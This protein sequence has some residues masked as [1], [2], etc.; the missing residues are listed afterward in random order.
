MKSYLTLTLASVMTASAAP[1]P[2]PP[3]KPVDL[4]GYRLSW[5]DEFDEL[6]IGNWR[7]DGKRWIAHTPW[8]GDFGDARF[9]GPGADSAF[10]IRD[11]IL[12]ITARKA[13]NGKWS[14]GLIS[15]VDETGAGHGLSEGYFET[16]IKVTPGPGTW[17][18]FWLFSKTARSDR[19][20]K[21]EIDALEFYGH[22]PRSFH[23][24]WKVHGRGDKARN[25]GDLKRIAIEPGAMSERFNTIGIQLTRTTIRYLFNRV[26]VWSAPRP[27]ELDTPM[28]PLV[29]LALG[30][31]YSIKQTPNPS[32]LE[33]DYVRLYAP[34][35][36]GEK[37]TCV[38]AEG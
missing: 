7:I 27:D 4:C 35:K 24:S 37:A 22:D 13:A 25:R 9:T 12:S 23:A 17:P 8:A 1:V 33:V 11:G 30:S 14:S 15:A 26:E 18:A 21:V 3:A 31:G 16:R 32:V 36:A 19:R 2:Q 38:P 20:P 6:S 28:F 29:N 34:A 5:S 10:S